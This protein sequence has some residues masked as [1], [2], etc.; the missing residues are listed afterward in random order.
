MA[1]ATSALASVMVPGH[2][3]EPDFLNSCPHPEAAPEKSWMAKGD[4]VR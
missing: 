4:E 1:A 2:R 3:R